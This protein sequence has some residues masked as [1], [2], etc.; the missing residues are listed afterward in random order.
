M[1]RNRSYVRCHFHDPQ[2][3][4]VRDESLT[5][6]REGSG[7]E[8]TFVE[9][10]VQLPI[11]LFQ[12]NSFYLLSAQSFVSTEGVDCGKQDGNFALPKS[13]CLRLIIFFLMLKKY[14]P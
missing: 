1:M 6:L 8:G 4:N 3:D 12:K 14:T 9:F 13:E 11:V 7:D 2:K 5:R 10:N